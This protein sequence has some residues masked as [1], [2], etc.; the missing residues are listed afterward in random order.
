M[1]SLPT[2]SQHP[3]SDHGSPPSPSPFRL[4]LHDSPSPRKG[5]EAILRPHIPA[6][7]FRPSR[8]FPR[9]APAPSPSTTF[10]RSPTT[11]H[12]LGFS[13]SSS[14][15]ALGCASPFHHGRPHLCCRRCRLSVRARS[16][17][18]V[19]CLAPIERGDRSLVARSCWI[20]QSNVRHHSR[21]AVKLW[22]TS[23][24]THVPVIV[25]R[26]TKMIRFRNES[27]RLLSQQ[28]YT[29]S[30]RNTMRVWSLRSGLESSLIFTTPGS[31]RRPSL[32]RYLDCASR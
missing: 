13:S 28:R 21:C 2:S 31:L 24:L 27:S 16:G 30:Y 26:Y 18:A 4:P 10:L 32:V 19:L 3:Q 7:R 14:S 29:T 20:G 25:R 15:L 23:S 1:L 11:T 22:E 17:P 9:H 8:A 6:F 12:R 5:P